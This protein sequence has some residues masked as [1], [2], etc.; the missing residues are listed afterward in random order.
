MKRQ[1]LID[2]RKVKGMTQKQ[3]AEAAGITQG[4]YSSLEN[5][6][7]GSRIAAYQAKGIAKTLDVDW[8]KF[9]E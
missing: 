3:V 7:R 6:T 5:G 4:N 2:A 9:Y 8:T 1:W